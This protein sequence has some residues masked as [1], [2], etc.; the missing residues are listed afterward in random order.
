MP[1]PYT[2]QCLCAAVKFEISSEPVTVLSCFC[3]HCSKGAGGTNQLIGKFATKDVQVTAPSS[4]I[5]TFTLTDTSSGSSKVKAFCRTCG[6]TLWTIPAAAKGTFH[7]IRLPLLDGGLNFRPGNE[8]FVKNRPSWQAAVEGVAQWDEMRKLFRLVRNQRYPV[9]PDLGTEEIVFPNTSPYPMPTPPTLHILSDPKTPQLLA[10]TRP[11]PA[12]LIILPSEA[13]VAH[14]IDV[15]CDNCRAK[16]VKC[17]GR[18]PGELHNVHSSLVHNFLLCEHFIN[19]KYAGGFVRSRESDTST[20]NP[21]RNGAQPPQVPDTHSHQHRGPVTSPEAG[22]RIS[23]TQLRVQSRPPPPPPQQQHQSPA[24]TT[25][26]SRR[27]DE[28]HGQRL[29]GASVCST[30]PSVIDSMTAVVD[31]GTSTGEFFGI[32]SAG[33]F[34]AQI[35]KAIDVRLGKSGTGPPQ[36]VP[37]SSRSVLGVTGSG[38][39]PASDISYVLP[40]RRQADHLMELYWFYVDPLYPFLDR[41]RWSHAYNATFAGTVIDFNERIFV[42]TLN[43][44]FA[45]STQLHES[46]SLEHREQSSEAYFKRAQELLPMSPW[47]SGSLELVQC[48]LVTSQYLQSTYNPHQTWM[49]VGS[50]IRTAQGLGLHLPE[51][52]DRADPAERE[53]LRRIWYGCVLMDRMVS[54]THGRPAMISPRPAT[55]VPLPV[56]SPLVETRDRMANPGHVSF[57]VQSVRLYEIIHQTMVTFYGGSNSSRTRARES[58][59]SDQGSDTDDDDLD[60][61]VQLDRSLSKWESKLP[62]HLRWNLLDGNK[63]EISRRQAVILRMRFVF[64]SNYLLS[65]VLTNE[66]RF[67]HARIL[68]LRPMLSRFCLTQSPVESSWVDDTL[69]ARVIQQGA[70]FCV[71]TAQTMITTLLKHQTSDNTVGLLPAWWYRVYYVYSAATVL[72]AAK[73]RPDAFSA[74]DIGRS[75]GQAI[76]VLK[77]HEKFGQSARRCVAA[78]HILSSKILQAVPGGSTGQ[79]TNSKKTSCPSEGTQLAQDPSAGLEIPDLV[80][81]LADEFATPM[82]DLHHQD[83]SDFNFDVNDMSWLND[84]QGVWELLNE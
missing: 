62:N 84:M 79:D 31:E 41:K 16:K 43:I 1:A 9:N 65:Q 27:G 34:T 10:P 5:G 39:M 75:W 24:G 30:S 57:F 20:M 35:K 19:E 36:D 48:L 46:Q 26:G 22:R 7:L 6:C 33:S 50:A 44:I 32:S 70:L 53:L 23:E 28:A 68:L 37:A 72:I 81:Q 71:S 60:K 13:P 15:A 17:D 58:H 49:V 64:T 56:S 4:A 55:A 69:Q 77:A 18:R 67:L 29:V 83:L 14:H 82:P 38:D 63:D 59:A 54:V 74:A 42:A 78:L 2:G 21:N 47:E 12:Q 25:P 52:S 8:I 73:L 76:S 3:D 11:N 40:P 66:S 45:L 51:T 61:V 80:Q